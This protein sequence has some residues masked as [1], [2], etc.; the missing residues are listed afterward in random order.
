M[1]ETPGGGRMRKIVVTAALLYSA[2]VWA[3]PPGTIVITR[4]PVDTSAANFEKDA[5]QKEVR[6]LD[7]SG[8]QWTFN[9]VA[10]LKKAAGARE[11]QLVF[12]DAAVKKHEPTNNFPI[13]TQANAKILTSS[14]SFNA[15][16]GFKVGHKY[17][18]LITR[19]VGGHEDV[20]ARSTI[21]LK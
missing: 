8:D 21:T 20:Y 10:F 17:S 16:Q 5:K 14:V 9:F 3:V 4:D 11:V 15:D 18:V 2:A 1:I 7:K 6:E 19:L 13:E 12:Y